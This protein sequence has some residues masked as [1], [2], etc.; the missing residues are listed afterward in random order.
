MESENINYTEILHWLKNKAKEFGFGDVR[1]TDLDLSKEVPFLK[2]WLENG[3]HGQMHYMARHENLRTDPANLQPG[4][5]RSISFRMDYLPRKINASILKNEDQ[6]STDFRE[7]ELE[8][9][10]DSSQAVVSLYA[11]GRDY[12]K[13][14]RKKLQSIATLLE[15]KITPLNY[16]VLVDSAPVLEVALASKAGIGW[17]GKHTLN[18]NRQSGSMY[19]LGEIL[20]DIPLPIDS[21]VSAHCG[22]CQDCLDICPTNAIVA[23]Y[24]LNANRCISYL[25]IEY[26]GSIP[27]EIRPFMGNRIYGCDDCQLVCHWNKFAQTSNLSDFD[28]RNSLD[29]SSLIDLFRWTKDE[30]VIKMQG[31]LPYWL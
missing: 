29:S 22:S 16:R 31:D 15:E 1:V 10:N 13:V 5:I 30:F 12:H 6:A 3:Y 25:T 17:R 14:L 11:R 8:R 28:V 19:F 9:L 23:P 27:I 20:V 2:K 7:L 26:S 4:V 21:P 24:Q 18:L